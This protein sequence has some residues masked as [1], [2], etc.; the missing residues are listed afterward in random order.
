MAPRS[1]G[2]VVALVVSS[3]CGGNTFTSGDG[4][5]AGSGGSKADGGAGTGGAAGKAGAGGSGGAASG[6][7]GS[8]GAAGMTGG[9]GGAGGAG[10]IAG[11]GGAAGMT[12][13]AGGA[14]GSTD[15]TACDGPGQCVAALKSCCASCSAPTVDQFAGVN[16]MFA[17]DFHSLQCSTPVACPNCA[18]IEN[19]N[20]AARCVSGKCEAFDVRKVPEFSACDAQNTCQLRL[21]LGCCVCGAGGG[22]S[23]QPWVAVSG[24]GE[25]ALTQAEC[26]PNTACADCLPVPP[27]NLL[28]ACMSGVCQVT[29]TSGGTCAPAPSGCCTSNGDCGTNQHCYG[30]SCAS[31]TA[32]VCKFPVATGL[33]WGDADCSMTQKC[34]GANI[35][36]CGAACLVA[37]TPGTCG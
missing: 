11:A 22:A 24:S 4:N 18:G 9:G 6:T 34:T 3:A 13:G 26:A 31:G 35:C 15:W 8:S 37:D 28:A 2:C 17:S 23:S 7:G 20:I 21:G 16:A 33:C 29:P 12:G 5:L 14:G 1:F 25:G 19:P 27:D 10:G 30:A 36:P 32:G